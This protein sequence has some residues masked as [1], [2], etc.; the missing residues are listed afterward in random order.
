MPDAGGKISPDQKNVTDEIICF[1]AS[2]NLFD[3]GNSLNI[4]FQESPVSGMFIVLP[5]M[6]LK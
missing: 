1:P 6:Y 3:A 4:D 2:N 5:G